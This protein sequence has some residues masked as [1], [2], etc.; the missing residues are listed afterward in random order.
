[1]RKLDSRIYGIDDTEFAGSISTDAL[2]TA[3]P[4]R[5]SGAPIDQEAHS[6]SSPKTGEVAD[7]GEATKHECNLEDSR[8]HSA[9]NHGE[10]D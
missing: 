4:N 1:M 9:G 8:A 10:Q 5:H 6:K 3:D 2:S 7:R